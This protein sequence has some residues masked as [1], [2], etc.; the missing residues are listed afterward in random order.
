MS[1][2]ALGRFRLWGGPILLLLAAFLGCRPQ[3]PPQTGV[4][5][6]VAPVSGEGRL[7]YVQIDVG[8]GDSQLIIS[9]DGHAMLVDAGPPGSADEILETLREYGVEKIDLLVESHPH[10]DHIGSMRQV[11]ERGPPVETFLASG[12]RHNSQV[13]ANLLREIRDRKTRGKLARKGDVFK[14]GEHVT[15]EVLQPEKPLL[16]GTESDPNNNSVVLRVGYGNTHFLLTG[17]ME[18]QERARLLTTREDLQSD[19][20]K[21]AHH[22]SHDGID[23]GFVRRVRPEYAILSAELGNDY[24]HP[25]EETIRILRDSNVEILRTDLHGAITLTSDGNQLAVRTEKNPS[26]PVTLTG[27]E[28]AARLGEPPSR[29]R[30]DKGSMDS[31]REREDTRDRRT[32]SPVPSRREGTREKAG[33]SRARVSPP[34]PRR[35]ERGPVIGNRRS[36]VYHI[37]GGGTN[38]PGPENR[39][40]FGSEAEARE[41][42]FRPAR[43]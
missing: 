4:S 25:H 6:D 39:V 14:L 15:V 34:G 8:Q 24:G 1:S 33:E 43:R 35:E 16:K 40:Y 22:G 18:A 41:A 42:G 5:N 2:H 37:E 21:A 13:Q 36:K 31:P 12:Y 19:V 38:L 20:L 27:K 28:T 17:D 10:A 29:N 7:T 23:P 3:S 26:V 32:K 9:P 11:I 30:S